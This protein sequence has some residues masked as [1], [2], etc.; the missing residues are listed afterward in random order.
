M[1]KAVHVWVGACE[2]SVGLPLGVSASI[3]PKEVY[4]KK[5]KR[6]APQLR[7]PWLA[8][9]RVA[10]WQRRPSVLSTGSC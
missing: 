1:E 9:E 2:K 7:P 6:S 5:K 10:H 8:N 4:V 3:T